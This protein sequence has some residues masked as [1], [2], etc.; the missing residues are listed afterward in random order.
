MTILLLTVSRLKITVK[1]ISNYTVF[2]NFVV[3][4]TNNTKMVLW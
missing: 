2:T 1:F 4:R 3:S